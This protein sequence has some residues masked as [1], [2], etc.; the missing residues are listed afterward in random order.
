MWNF[1]FSNFSC[2]SLWSSS[3]SPCWIMWSKNKNG[4]GAFQ[5]RQYLVSNNKPIFPF[6][7]YTEK[8]ELSCVKFSKTLFFM[9]RTPNFRVSPLRWVKCGEAIS[10]TGTTVAGSDHGVSA[11][12]WERDAAACGFCLP[13]AAWGRCL[14]EQVF[15]LNLWYVTFDLFRAAYFFIAFRCAVEVRLFAN[16][17]HQK[18]R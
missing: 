12:I 6:C 17:L 8:A 15:V 16:K 4:N 7:L 2:C 10:D 3:L 5:R 9:R 14:Y 1:P 18:N 13:A 11:E